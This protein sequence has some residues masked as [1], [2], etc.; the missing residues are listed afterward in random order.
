MAMIYI[1]HRISHGSNVVVVNNQSANSKNFSLPFDW[2]LTT[3]TFA[4]WD[5]LWTMLLSDEIKTGRSE[6][7]SIS[8]I[9]SQ[10]WKGGREGRT[11]KTRIWSLRVVC[12]LFIL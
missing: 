8:P 1:V 3:T 12:S 9:I 7:L 10:E 5:I 2:M 6:M 11:E 4:P